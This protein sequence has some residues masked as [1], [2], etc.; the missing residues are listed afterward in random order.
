MSDEDHSNFQF[1]EQQW[2][3]LHD[4]AQRAGAAVATNPDVTA[5]RLRGFTERM[6]ELLFGHFGLQL[7]ADQ[8]QYDRLLLLERDSLLERRLLAKFH[9]IRK[10]GNDGAHGKAVT[11]ER[12]GDLVY[13]AWTLGCWFAR[14]MRPDVDWLIR[15]YGQRPRPDALKSEVPAFPSA[16]GGTRPQDNVVA[17]PEDRVRRIR[18]EVAAALAKVDP[19]IRNLRTRMSLREAFVEDLNGD[20][21]ACADALEAFLSDPA[22]RIMLLK[23]DAGAGKTFMAKGL[24]EYLASQGRQYAIGAP[25]GRAAKI[26]GEKTGRRAR[27]LH[28]LIYDYGNLRRLGE[29]GEDA[30]GLASF[31][32]YASVAANRD[33]ANTVYI[34]DEASLVSDAF[35]ESDFF[36]SGSGYLLKDL[37]DY[38]G[39]QTP[40]T[41]RKIIFIG[42]PVQLTPVDMNTSP[43]LDADYL[44]RHYG[45]RPAEYRLT[46]IVRQ[47][48]ESSILSNVKPLRMGVEEGAFRGLS[49][50]FDDDVVRLGQGD[51]VPTYLQTVR[52]SA[53]EPMVI[54]RSN[55][56]AAEINRAVRAEIFP[57]Q[58][59]VRPGDRLIITSNTFVG[60]QFL[61]NGEFVEVCGVEPVVERKSVRLTRRV[62]DTDLTE[63]VD[64]ELIFRDI[65]IAMR[66]ENGEQAV[67]QVKVIDT[68][69]HDRNSGL[70]PDEQR[71]LYVDFLR[72]H[73]DIRKADPRALTD[74]IRQD[75]Y[76]NAMRAKF[77]YAVTC[78]KAQGGEWD[79]VIVLCPGGGDPRNEDAFRWLYTAMT[80]ARSR[81]FLVNPPEVR[82]KLAGPS[83]HDFATGAV[84]RAADQNGPTPLAAFRKTL[85]ARSRAA[86]EGSGISVDDVGHHQYQEVLYCSRET[87]GCRASLSYNGKFQ[88]RSMTIHPEGPLA[89]DVKELVGPLVGLTLGIDGADTDKKAT[90]PTRPFIAE[91]DAQFRRQLAG[92]NISVNSMQEHQWSLR[93]VMARDNRQATIDIY[94]DG[95][96]RFTRCMP[97]NPDDSVDGMDLMREVVGIVTTEIIA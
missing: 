6:V 95:K 27:T 91:F 81:L 32:V 87:D 34:V 80:R 75:P 38:V 48:A 3:E 1:L 55:A 56:E 45:Y 16:E 93:Y 88:L 24:V 58:D 47:G 41:D 62:G 84:A 40:G 65:E 73:P 28:S 71:A 57:G 50:D 30:S 23:G 83:I 14:L 42:D 39:T 36:R 44:H 12:A 18:Q 52:D 53:H 29:D 94:F 4:L 92:R 69:L 26:I 66:M 10:F 11:S 43:A 64:I 22:Q 49:F 54:T 63:K 35:S 33:S 86:L 70:S 20:Q 51:L 7:I 72:R 82:I 78:H 60:G 31:K 96:D 74:A 2:P 37:L 90:S 67:Q 79:E 13:D 97:I 17:F 9:T 25:T 21:S 89:D 46:E 59:H 19:E 85:L 5:V 61:A 76:F 15:P 77:G 68:L 8:S